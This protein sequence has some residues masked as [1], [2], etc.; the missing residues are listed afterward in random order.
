MSRFLFVV[1]PLVGHTNPTIGVAAQLVERGHEVAWAGHEEFLRH[2][3]GPRAAV[4]H[5]DGPVLGPEGAKRPPEMRGPAALKFLWENFLAPLARGMVPG[6][7]AACAEFRPDV[8]VVDQQAI[9]GA[10]VANSLGLPWATSATTSAEFTDPLATMPKVEEW[11]RELLQGLQTEFGDPRLDVDLRFSPHLTLAFTTRALIGETAHE[12]VRF[13]GPSITERQDGDDFPDS[14]LD[15]SRA[16][17]LLTLGTANADAGER[18]LREAVTALIDRADRVQAIIA[19]PAGVLTEHPGGG[20]IV[21][22]RVPVLRLLDRLDAVICHAGH[23]TV[24]ETLWHGLPLVVAPI[25][26]DQPIVAQQVVDSGAGVRVRFNRATAEQIGK[27]VDTALSN[28]DVRAAAERVRDSFR[29][30][31]GAAGAAKHLELLAH[32]AT[33]TALAGTGGTTA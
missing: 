24:C 21:A 4:L 29:A 9:A 25:R 3:V 7:R 15:D 14:E 17:V 8:L 11:L 33:A 12:N 6:V 22:P 31:G 19:D 10:I 5:C 18:F 1:P 23:N 28:G 16:K 20:A 32:D 27:A 30:A 26:D 2:L 13:V